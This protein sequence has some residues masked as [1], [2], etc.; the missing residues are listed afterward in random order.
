V[1]AFAVRVAA[2]T[3]CDPDDWGSCGLSDGDVLLDAGQGDQA[4]PVEVDE[5]IAYPQIMAE[6]VPDHPGYYLGNGT[7]PDYPWAQMEVFARGTFDLQG[8]I[9]CIYNALAADLFETLEGVLEADVTNPISQRYALGFSPPQWQ[10]GA[11]TDLCNE[12]ELEPFLSNSLTS[13]LGGWFER[14][15]S[16]TTPDEIMGW[17]PINKD[18]PGYD[19]GLY[20]PSDPDALII[21]EHWIGSGTFSWLMPDGST[22]TP[23]SAT[24]EVLDITGDTML[25]KWRD[26]GY[27]AGNIPVY[28]QASYE[29]DGQELTIKWGAFGDT[30]GTAPQVFLEPGDTCNDTDVIC[31]DNNEYHGGP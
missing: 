19:A 10:W 28:Q 29:Q 18:G 26:I 7:F 17:V 5:A 25:L 22:V 24:A 16:G 27:K 3:G 2:A 4:I 12:Q 1:P 23:F 13:R 20:D 8:H 14:D 31:Y 30:A 9:F 6:P 11:E 21:R 15:E